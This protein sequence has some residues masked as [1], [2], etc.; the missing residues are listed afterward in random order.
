MLISLKWQTKA[1]NFTKSNT[2]PWVFFTFFKLYNWY[3]IAQSITYERSGGKKKN[4]RRKSSPKQEIAE[5]VNSNALASK[6]SF[7]VEYFNLFVANAPFLYRPK[8]SENLIVFWCSQGIEKV[9]IG[10]KSV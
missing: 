5:I 4:F 10:N 2:P 9:C 3:K 1:C 6:F 8:T 7:N